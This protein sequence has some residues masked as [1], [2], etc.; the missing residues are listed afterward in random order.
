M[1]PIPGP[2][3]DWS[4]LVWQRHGQPSELHKH[5]FTI[6]VICIAGFIA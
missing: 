5:R 3:A 2:K 4:R 1:V 6:Q